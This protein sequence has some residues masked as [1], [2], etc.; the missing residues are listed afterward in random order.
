LWLADIT[1][2]PTR[3]GWLFLAVV[4][5]AFSR[6]IVGWSMR[7]DL[8]SELVVDALAMAVTRRKPAPRRRASQ[9]PRLAGRIQSVVA[10]LDQ[11]ELR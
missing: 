9:R 6:R 1:Y 3:E 4:L 8:K 11:E 10:T 7:D 2:L 5:D